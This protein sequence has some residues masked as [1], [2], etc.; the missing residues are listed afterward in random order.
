MAATAAA[1]LV[2]LLFVSLSL[3]G[4]ATRNLFVPLARGAFAAYVTIL[5]VAFLFLAPG[6][7]EI[8][9]GVSLIVAAGI[10]GQASLATLRAA[11][12]KRAAGGSRRATITRLA[13]A[14]LAVI[15]LGVSGVLSLLGRTD[16]T[17]VAIAIAL[18]GLQAARS[19]WDVL[20]ARE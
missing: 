16:L 17:L 1:T 9:F 19:S 6:L 18:L 8:S 4:A 11:R 14:A 12:E 10:N 3:H 2:G 5:I 13:F 7:S 20:L 15:D